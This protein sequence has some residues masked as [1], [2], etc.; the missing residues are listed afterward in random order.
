MSSP[1]LRG[2]DSPGPTRG[3]TGTRG[4]GEIGPDEWRSGPGVP[5]GARR[6]G[7]L[8]TSSRHGRS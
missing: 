2:Q 5:G 4:P 3:L 8:P 7:P 6:A 1:R